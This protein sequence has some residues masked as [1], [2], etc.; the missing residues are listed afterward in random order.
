MPIREV[1]LP[2][3]PG[4]NMSSIIEIAARNELLRQAGHHPA[5]DLVQQIEAGLLTTDETGSR[6]RRP[7]STQFRAIRA[8]ESAA[9]PP[10]VP[11]RNKP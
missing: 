1:C 4:R 3:Q 5:R 6:I 2:V 7:P 8:N 9:P 11:R 10:V